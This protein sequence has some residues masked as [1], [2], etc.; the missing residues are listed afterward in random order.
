ML[1]SP[2]AVI[3]KHRRWVAQTIGIHFLQFWRLG[4]PRSR[5]QQGRVLFSWHVDD[6]HL[7]LC[8]H[9]CFFACTQ[10][11][12]Q[13]ERQSL[14]SLLTIRTQSHHGGLQPHVN[15]IISK[16]PTSDTITLGIWAIIDEF[17][18][19]T[20]IQF[21]TVGLRHPPPQYPSHVN[22]QAWPLILS[23][24]ISWED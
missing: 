21:I 12:K 7:P 18:G 20:N 2:W 24:P 11:D 23:K 19:D 5:C 9:G 10:R 22:S 16:V 15:L 14:V 1:S 3:T 8:S 13:K 17:M 4:N 6:H